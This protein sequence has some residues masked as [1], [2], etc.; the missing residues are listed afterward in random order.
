VIPYG[1]YNRDG[2]C[3]S[4]NT[5]EG[6]FNIATGVDIE[7]HSA[8]GRRI[9]F[10]AIPRGRCPDRTHFSSGMLIPKSRSGLGS[11]RQRGVLGSDDSST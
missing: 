1:T 6:K 8:K 5:V 11:Y 9:S 7:K 10:S 3:G 4:V 2:G